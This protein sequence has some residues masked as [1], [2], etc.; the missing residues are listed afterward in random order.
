MLE[1]REVAS[2]EAQHTTQHKWNEE[3]SN[4]HIILNAVHVEIYCHT[5]NFCIPL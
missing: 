1:A 3:Y 2:R 4:G 5:L